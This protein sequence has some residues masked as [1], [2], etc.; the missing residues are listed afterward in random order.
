MVAHSSLGEGGP[1][2]S[3]RAS[4]GEPTFALASE[5]VI[6]P[7]RT[8]CP[9]D[10]AADVLVP[11]FRETSSRAQPA[12]QS[13][14]PPEAAS[15][16]PV[17]DPR[18]SGT[19][20]ASPRHAGGH[21]RGAPPSVSECRTCTAADA[22]RRLRTSARRPSGP[23]AN[24]NASQTRDQRHERHPPQKML[25]PLRPSRPSDRGPIRDTSADSPIQSTCK[26]S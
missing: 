13:L 25:E 19:R 11:G 15:R 2:Q 7:A 6:Q 22:S 16:G 14:R 4:V 20:A 9:T 10:S 26:N 12:P 5:R 3:L 1:A 24:Y 21:S 18:G 8:A 17:S 23:P